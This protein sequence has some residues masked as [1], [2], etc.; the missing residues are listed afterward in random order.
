MVRGALALLLVLCS[1]GPAAALLAGTQCRAVP[2][3]V[4]RPSARCCAAEQAVVEEAPEPCDFPGCDGRGRALGGLAAIPLFSWWPIKVHPSPCT[5]RTPA[6]A[7]ARLRIPALARLRASAASCFCSA[8]SDCCCRR[9]RQP[10]LR[11][12]LLWRL[13]TAPPARAGVPPVPDLRRQ[14]HEVQP[15][16]ADARRDR[17]QEAP[18][19]VREGERAL[20]PGDTG[21]RLDHALSSRRTQRSHLRTARSA[22]LGGS[23]RLWAALGGS[24]LA[25]PAPVRAEPARASRL[26]GRRSDP[27][28]LSLLLRTTPGTRRADTT[29]TTATLETA[30]P[31]SA[32]WR[33]AMAALWPWRPRL[34]SAVPAARRGVCDPCSKVRPQTDG[35]ERVDK[36]KEAWPHVQWL[37]VLLPCTE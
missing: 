4:A 2:S 33:S 26:Q 28:P 23:G 36:H 15:K 3:L 7:L 37:C 31:P 21:G 12:R 17:L 34:A 25:G 24:A 13:L 27:P 30:R 14:G 18:Q 6:P 16:R 22:A 1:A 11:L 35:V 9:S 29:A 10:L 5:R 8:A 19:P 32:H 20:R